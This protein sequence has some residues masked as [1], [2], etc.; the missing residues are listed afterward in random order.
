MAAALLAALTAVWN[1]DL[2]RQL[3]L[4]DETSLLL[5][6]PNVVLTFSLAASEPGSSAF[7]RVVLDLDARKGAV[8]IR[9]LPPAQPGQV[10]RLWALVGTKHVP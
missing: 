1:H 8:V 5:Q 2:R 4:L 7:G 3:A 9:R 10:Y 6:Q